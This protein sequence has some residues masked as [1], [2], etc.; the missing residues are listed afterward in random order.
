MTD[1]DYNQL[2]SNLKSNN[3]D[4]RSKA[5][6]DLKTYA[7]NNYP[8]FLLDSSIYVTN[9]KVD[10]SNRQLCGTIMKNMISGSPGYEMFRNYWMNLD[11]NSRSI[12]KNNIISSLGSNSDVVKSTISSCISAICSIEFPHKQWYNIFDVLEK[13]ALMDD[14]NYRLASI[15]TIRNIMQDVPTSSVTDTDL[16]RVL[17][18]I[19]NNANIQMPASIRKEAINALN[20]SIINLKIFM[21]DPPKKKIIFDM[22]IA[23]INYPEEDLRPIGYLCLYEMSRYF[24]FDIQD[25]IDPMLNISKAYVSSLKNLQTSNTILN[26]ILDIW[27]DI[28][29]QEKFF[30]S[31]NFDFNKYI[32]S[33]Q[34]DLFDICIQILKLRRQD[35][36]NDENEFTPY[37]LVGFLIN[38]MSKCCSEDFIKTVMN[39]IG[40][41]LNNSNPL[42][43]HSAMTL[44]HSIIDSIHAN[45]ISQIVIDG[46]DNIVNNIND[47]DYNLR[48]ITSE[49]VYKIGESHYKSFP[50]DKATLLL[51]LI[52]EKLKDCKEKGILKN[53]ILALHAI[54]RSYS[55]LDET[56]DFSQ[57]V[58]IFSELLFNITF[59]FNNYDKKH[60]VSH[61]GTLALGT[62]LEHSAMDKHL[63]LKEFLYKLVNAFDTTMDLTKFQNNL[64]I[65]EQYQIYLCSCISSILALHRFNL[66][67]EEADYLYKIIT[68]IFNAKKYVIPEG[69]MTIS[70]I[71]VCK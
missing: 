64:E 56:N 40:I 22:I 61:S 7:I 31:Q 5:E 29:K 27:I 33:K 9:D 70:N 52:Y 17:F 54:A 58:E 43:K 11:E 62:I 69:L 60:N 48:E 35:D 49:I 67:N 59:D 15:R 41:W 66:S 13:A 16:G 39:M 45:V 47:N 42:L 37:K 3:N 21:K 38:N 71:V 4:L 23:A 6:N 50:K 20:F 46:F 25:L 12:I 8:K 68:D 28:S 30:L 65:Q 1:I 53:L 24:Y 32:D 51:K 2:F 19:M 44:F 34:N 63:F 36:Y 18:M 55:S 14:T 10:Q 57:Y 26:N